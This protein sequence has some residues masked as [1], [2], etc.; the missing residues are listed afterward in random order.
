MR[1]LHGPFLRG[2][3]VLPG[4]SFL[5]CLARNALPVG[6]MVYGIRMAR[7]RHGRLQGLVGNVGGRS[8][9]GILVAVPFMAQV[10]I[11]PILV[12]KDN[13]PILALHAVLG[14]HVPAAVR[15]LSAAF[16]TRVSVALEFGGLR[17]GGAFLLLISLHDGRQMLLRRL[18]PALRVRLH[19]LHH[20]RA[21]HHLPPRRFRRARGSQPFLRNQVASRQQEQ[22]R[23]HGQQKAH[24]PGNPEQSVSPPLL[25]THGGE[26]FT[27]P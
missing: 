23:Q 9:S 3:A 25:E 21:H 8:G 13:L 22:V 6:R 12:K 16:R 26:V 14:R 1:K 2:A 20:A 17:P 11:L 7:G 27:V 24:A 10:A 4:Q 5:A 15:V 18:P 19:L